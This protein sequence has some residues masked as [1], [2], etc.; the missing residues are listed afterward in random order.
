MAGSARSDSR[1]HPAARRLL[2]ATV[3]CAAAFGAIAVIWWGVY[4]LRPSDPGGAA[5]VIT[6]GLPVPLGAIALGLTAAIGWFVMG[7]P[8][9]MVVVAAPAY[10]SVV[11][12]L[13]FPC[14]FLPQ[15]AL[16]P[17]TLLALGAMVAVVWRFVAGRSRGQVGGVR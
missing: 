13:L 5:C 3:W 8:E 2:F 10:G 9:W 1:R 15:L 12:L 17:L 7:S 6:H 11:L 14:T 4:S 16:P